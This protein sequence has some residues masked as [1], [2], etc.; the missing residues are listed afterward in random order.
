M[1]RTIM[2]ERNKQQ[3][4]PGNEYISAAQRRDLIID[5][6]DS[7]AMLYHHYFDKAGYKNFDLM[8]DNNT[9]YA[10]AWPVRKVAKERRKLLKAYWVFIQTY[11]NPTAGKFYLTILGKQAVKDFLSLHGLNT[12]GDIKTSAIISNDFIEVLESYG[13]DNVSKCIIRK[14]E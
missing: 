6:G 7:G 2:R 8:D 3:K 12:T 14:G 1:N 11:T 5:V 9:A 10:I 13:E 4:K